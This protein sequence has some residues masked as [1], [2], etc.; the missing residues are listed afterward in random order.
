MWCVICKITPWPLTG[1]KAFPIFLKVFLIHFPGRRTEFGQTETGTICK[2][3][4]YLTVI[5]FKRHLL[6]GERDKSK[7]NFNSTD[8]LWLTSSID[9]ATNPL[10]SGIQ[11]SFTITLRLSALELFTVITFECHLPFAVFL[12]SDYGISCIWK[13]PL[14][15][16]KSPFDGFGSGV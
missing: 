12:F 3:F 2:R 16:I 8:Q 7:Y 9:H 11:K 15:L 1:A 4:Y 5:N 10:A 13:P 6:S 14:R